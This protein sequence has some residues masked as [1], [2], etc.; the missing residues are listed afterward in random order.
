MRLSKLSLAGVPPFTASADFELS[1]QVNLFVGPNASGKSTVLRAL[2]GP[3]FGGPSNFLVDEGPS[4][5][6]TGIFDSDESNVQQYENRNDAYSNFFEERFFLRGDTYFTSYER[7]FK[8]GHINYEVE[9]T[10][11]RLSY[12]ST[13]DG[14]HHIWLAVPFLYVPA[15]RINVRRMG[16]LDN[17]F[18]RLGRDVDA[19]YL[20]QLFDTDSGVFQ[21]QLVDLATSQLN[22]LA[23]TDEESRQFREAVSVGFRCA[24]DICSEVIRGDK[25][26]AYAE[27]MD[28]GERMP[29]S[30]LHQT[31]GVFTSDVSNGESLF[32]G[33]LSSGTQGPLLWIR[34]LVL[35]IVQ[36]YNFD[37]DCMKYPAI[38]LIDEIENHLHPEWQRRV[39]PALLEHFPGLQI[40]AT[41]HSP[42][43][44]AGLEAGEVHQLR[45]HVDG[46]ISV[47][48]NT[49]D[50]IGWTSDEISRR[51]LDIRTPTDLTIIAWSDRLMELRRKE[52]LTADEEEELV[53]LRRR[54]NQALLSGMDETAG[55]EAEADSFYRNRQ[56]DLTQD[57]A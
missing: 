4:F 15:T 29:V 39:I 25:V 32:A 2:K 10:R 44:I 38:L 30:V 19:N 46:A 43:V 6:T 16:D 53:D 18:A 3:P 35:K 23:T 26:E 48:T 24:K 33:D 41:T 55:N 7:R 54:V 40:F 36:H 28:D 31:L 13:A 8:G 9:Y 42:F 47:T 11:E 49:E 17:T 5:G 45:R 37:I 52:N 56:S 20:N 14:G 27:T 1:H 57:G 51:L 12:Y 22:E 21:G 34:A 50:I